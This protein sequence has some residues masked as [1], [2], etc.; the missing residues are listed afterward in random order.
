MPRHMG[1]V[2]MWIARRWAMGG[3]KQDEGKRAQWRSRLNGKTHGTARRRA[4]AGGKS[5]T[6]ALVSESPSELDAGIEL[7]LA[8]G[9]RVRIR[10]GVDEETLRTV[11]SAVGSPC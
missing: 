11:L 2:L 6:F 4:L 1:M 5:A 7:V 8:D 3:R 9:R 10:R